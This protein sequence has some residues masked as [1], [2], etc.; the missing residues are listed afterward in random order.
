[1]FIFLVQNNIFENYSRVFG[2]YGKNVL[3]QAFIYLKDK[4][5][6]RLNEFMQLFQPQNPLEIV[7]KKIWLSRD[8]YMRQRWNNILT[9]NI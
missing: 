1:M 4:V 6:R 9:C 5:I 7:F 2:R 8:E 3:Q